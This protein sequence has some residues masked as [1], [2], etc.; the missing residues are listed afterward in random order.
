MLGETK[1]QI[2]DLINKIQVFDFVLGSLGT[3]HKEYADKIDTLYKTASNHKLKLIDE[4]LRL[5]GADKVDSIK[6]VLEV[7]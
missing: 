4:L 5:N 3:N 7:K 6:T 1:Q 2:Q